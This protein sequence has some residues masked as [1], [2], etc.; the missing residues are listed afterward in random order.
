MLLS[1]VKYATLGNVCTVS[2]ITGNVKYN[3]NKKRTVFNFSAD[4]SNAIYVC[5]LD[6]D[7]FENCK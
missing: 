2:R 6:K 7:D 3:L 4:N 1:E 5:K